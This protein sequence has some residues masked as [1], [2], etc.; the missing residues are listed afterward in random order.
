MALLYKEQALE[1]ISGAFQIIDLEKADRFQEMLIEAEE[2][3]CDGLGRS[4]LYCRAFAMRL[5]H[6]GFRCNVVGDVLAHAIKSGDLLV[7]CSASGESQALFS[8]A[9][10]AEKCGA[11]VVLITRNANS[12]LAQTVDL[13][14]L[15]KAPSKEDMQTKRNSIM[16][17]GTLFEETA[18]LFFDLVILDLMERLDITNQ[19]MSKRHANLE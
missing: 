8:H 3:F 17:M 10:K 4:G 16:P 6:M 1:E 12:L 5:M 9:E 2:I 14:L 11:R 13:C 18:N 7:I 19:I 15:V